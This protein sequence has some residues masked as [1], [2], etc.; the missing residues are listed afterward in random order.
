MHTKQSLIK[1]RQKALA[2][3]LK[4]H[5]QICI[6]K[7]SFMS[8]STTYDCFGQIN[9]VNDR[10]YLIKNKNEYCWSPTFSKYENDYYFDQAIWFTNIKS[11]LKFIK[12]IFNKDKNLNI[13]IYNYYTQYYVANINTIINDLKYI[14]KKGLIQ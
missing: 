11:V 4:N 5:F 1:K 8:P 10:N 7:D 6:F 12:K 3:C 9:T 2:F 13:G 14:I